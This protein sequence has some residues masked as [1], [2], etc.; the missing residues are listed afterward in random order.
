MSLLLVSLL[1]ALALVIIF[2]FARRRGT[3]SP[4]VPA[5]R[6]IPGPTPSPLPSPPPTIAF[7]TALTGELSVP[8]RID[9]TVTSASS[10][11][12]RIVPEYSTDG[13]VT[14]RAATERGGPPSE[15][16]GN[17]SSSPAG[18][19]HVFVWDAAADLAPNLPRS[20]FFAK[21]G[22]F[23]AQ[24]FGA[25]PGNTADTGPFD[26]LAGVRLLTPAAA[27]LA[28]QRNALW[29][30]PVPV[31]YLLVDQAA[32]PMNVTVT[33]SLDGGVTFL[34]A[35]E[36][37]GVG[38]EGVA[39]LASSD[40][41]SGG[42]EH[43]F[44]W[45]AGADLPGTAAT[46]VLL[47][48]DTQ[49][50][51]RGASAAVDIDRRFASTGTTKPP[52]TTSIPEID[53]IVAA[54]NIGAHVP[55]RFVVIDP[56]SNRVDVDVRVA[57]AGS[58]FAPAVAA[59]MSDTMTNLPAPP[60]WTQFR[61][62]WNAPGNNVTNGPAQLL[63]LPRRG[64]VQIGPAVTETVNVN[65][66]V[67]PDAGVLAYTAPPQLLP[68]TVDKLGGTDRQTG[69]IHAQLPPTAR[70][71]L[72]PR[73]LAV[74]VTDTSGNP[75][76]GARVSFEVLAGSPPIAFER[77]TQYWPTTDAIGTAGINVRARAGAPGT[78]RV[79]AT[80]VGA[81]NHST[82]FEFTL[83]AP[84][85]ELNTPLPPGPYGY[86][87]RVDVEVRY[88]GVGAANRVDFGPE[89]FRPRFLNV[90]PTNCV[91][92][93]ARVR[94]NGG[95]G[96]P[97]ARVAVFPTILD[98]TAKVRFEDPDDPTVFFE[99]LLA[100]ST[101][102]NA[103][104]TTWDAAG[105]PIT[106]P[107]IRLYMVP[108][109]PPFPPPPTATT[110]TTTPALPAALIGFPG[111]TLATAF[112]I[113]HVTDTT[114]VIYNKENQGP[115]FGCYLAPTPP[116]ASIPPLRLI[117]VA[118]N[119]TL[120][121][122]PGPGTSNTVTA[123]VGAPVY[124]TPAGA[125]PWF[126]T[127]STV[128]RI[129]DTRSFD[130]FWVDSSGNQQCNRQ[131]DIGSTV[132]Y[133]FV[134]QEPKDYRF[135]LTAGP[136]A[137]AVVT[138]VDAGDRA[139]L[140][141]TIST[142]VAGTPGDIKFAAH[143]PGG[144]RP[145]AYTLNGNAVQFAPTARMRVASAGVLHSDEFAVARDWQST[146]TLPVFIVPFGWIEA[147]G[148]A[149]RAP[150]AVAGREVERQTIAG[151][152]SLQEAA[153]G[154]TPHLGAAGSVLAHGGEFVYGSVDLS[155]RSRPDDMSFGRTYC[156]HLKSEGM[157]GPGW[158]FAHERSLELTRD[159]GFR[160]YNGTGRFDD[161]TGAQP[162]PPKGIFVEV[163]AHTQIDADRSAFEITYP[164][165]TVA[166]FNY[167]GSLRFIRDRVRNTV[168]YRY[169]EQARLVEI[170]DPLSTGAA[171]PRV[172]RLEYWTAG[173]GIAKE[174]EGKLKQ[175]TDFAGRQ[176]GFEY[177]QATGPDGAAGWLKTVSPP[178]APAWI[179]GALDPNHRRS[180]SYRY[181]VD[182]NDRSKGVLREIVD[183]EGRTW[184]KNAHDAD[185]RVISQEYGDPA[186]SRQPYKFTY[187]AGVP[188][189]GPGALIATPAI[190]STTTMSDRRGTKSEYLFPASPYWD[191]CAPAFVCAYGTNEI[192]FHTLQ[193]NADGHTVLY[194]L[195]AGAGT[196]LSPV[197]ETRFAY[198]ERATVRSRGNLRT[199]IRRSSGGE[200][201]VW[202]YAYDPTYNYVSRSADARANASGNS[203][204]LAARYYY[205]SNGNLETIL[206]PSATHLAVAARTNNPRGW[207]EMRNQDDREI[208]TYNSFG[209]L[210]S[211]ADG[212]G[213]VTQYAYHPESAPG[214][215]AGAPSDAHGGFSARMEVDAVD[216]PRRQNHVPGPQWSASP[217]DTHTTKW[218]WNDVGDLIE[219]E[220]PDGTRTTYDADNSR[221]PSKVV[222][223]AG[224]PVAITQRFYHDEHSGI[225]RTELDQPSLAALSPAAVAK[226]GGSTLVHEWTRDLLGNVTAHSATLEQGRIVVERFEFDADDCI[227]RHRPVDDTSGRFAGAYTQYDRDDRGLAT[228]VTHA[229]G[230]TGSTARKVDWTA[231][232]VIGTFT[233]PANDSQ[234]S[235]R[236][237]YGDAIGAV[238]FDQA[239]A[240][241]LHDPNATKRRVYSQK[242]E[243]GN[244]FVHFDETVHDEAGRLMRIHAGVFRPDGM[245]PPPRP[246]PPAVAIGEPNDSFF[247]VPSF[248][249]V[250]LA[251]APDGKWGRGDGRSTLDL[252]Y[253]GPH[254]TRVVDDEGAFAWARRDAHGR[255]VETYES[256]RTR[257]RA[258]YDKN[259]RIIE[260]E[261]FDESSTVT[262]RTRWQKFEYDAHGR[263]TRYVDA[264]GNTYAFEYDETGHCVQRYD[265]MGPPDTAS[266]PYRG[267]ALNKPGNATRFERDGFG[268]I[269]KTE[270]ALTQ[271]GTSAGAPDVTTFNPTA[272]TGIDVAYDEAGRLLSCQGQTGNPISWQYDAI[273]R[274]QSTTYSGCRASGGQP[275]LK[276]ITYDGAGRM[277]TS[278]DPNATRLR[279]TYDKLGH[280]NAIKV[281]VRGSGVVGTDEL[282]YEVKDNVVTATD[283]TSGFVSRA[284]DDSLGRRIFAIEG[285]LVL[286]YEYDG[287]GLRTRLRRPDGSEIGYEHDQ[288]R[289]LRTVRDGNQVITRLDYLSTSLVQFRIQGG[290]QT[291]YRYRD[292]TLWL[293][294]ML[295]G[296]VAGGLIQYRLERDRMGRITKR[297]RT[298]AGAVTVREWR[299]DSVGRIVFERVTGTAGVVETTRLYDSDGALRRETV[300]A[301]G[302]TT[303]FDQDSEERGRILSRAGT[304]YG[305]DLAGHLL[306]DGAQRYAWDACSRLM[307]V[308]RGAQVIAEYEYDAEHRC[309]AKTAGTRREEYL[310]DDW[311]LIEV[312]V[313]GPGT[314]VVSERYVWSDRLDDL[315]AIETNG[316]K[317]I[318]LYTPEGWVDALVDQQ[319][320]IVERYEYDLAGRVTV[321]DASGTPVSNARPRSRFLFQRRIYDPDTGLYDYR[322]R[323]Y[324]PRI[325]QFLTPDPSG[326]IEGPDHYWLNHGDPVNNV[327][328]Y[329]M[330][331]KPQQGEDKRNTPP[332][333]PLLPLL[334]NDAADAHSNAL[335]RRMIDAIPLREVRGHWTTLIEPEKVGQY[336]NNAQQSG[337][338]FW[339]YEKNARAPVP[340]RIFFSEG[341]A[342][343]YVPRGE[344]RMVAA[345]QLLGEKAT[346]KDLR[347]YFEEIKDND[348]GQ[349]RRAVTSP[350]K[351]G[352]LSDAHRQFLRTGQMLEIM[353][354]E[355]FARWQAQAKA[356]E[357]KPPPA[358][359]PTSTFASALRVAGTIVQGILVG[360][361]IKAVREHGLFSVQSADAI[362]DIPPYVA[363]VKGS[364][365][366]AKNVYFDALLESI[367]AKAAQRVKDPPPGRPNDPTTIQDE[368]VYDTAI[369]RMS[370][371]SYRQYLQRRQ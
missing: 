19:A 103:Q 78:G 113:D 306:D 270:T 317:Y 158:S 305:Y 248:P 232:A 178:V 146:A 20:D 258:T 197:E 14:Y 238:D 214:G 18:T 180:E 330:D 280:V 102:N 4:P 179:N 226:A 47:R 190:A 195:A 175:L 193:H 2:F 38:S 23:R 60:H 100:V 353:D 290:I 27:T 30:S 295:I 281:E 161:F 29:G 224:T 228:T 218:K 166:H 350:I 170:T 336:V 216:S 137:G 125:G 173:P 73:S 231:N 323:W 108:T 167:D 182:P 25:Q 165:M 93:Q 269:V 181:D 331:D 302:T 22:R 1:L 292:G 299:Y 34:P 308:S 291:Q 204:M 263:M 313:A 59:P 358:T 192:R 252:S 12:V 264:G 156:G 58:N 88:D 220:T 98:G 36:A 235:V 361:A 128:G 289:M 225:A 151:I 7:T 95:T 207:R 288:T 188:A 369:G 132:S 13:G 267:N 324:H 3:S 67:P 355:A 24:V 199:V 83:H 314:P 31:R 327:D 111:L 309:I 76:Q 131:N 133:T 213:V 171:M 112:K 349:A 168:R 143:L 334:L 209:L 109:S 212:R 247:G 74:R 300:N 340:L 121:T 282:R 65:A 54:N 174:V 32:D 187:A 244:P 163:A 246:S 318:V 82:T 96:S 11:R 250:A 99:V 8:I 203:E 15:G 70:G 278:T 26:V 205:T 338:I 72:L 277:D 243:S 283:A 240:T 371:R 249:G 200:E 272:T 284:I 234:S 139:R 28:G 236:D 107:N 120:S 251:S 145:P 347:G 271:D 69:F 276:S 359:A 84:K 110:T 71:H 259:H 341:R 41:A 48:I 211:H 147:Q 117:Y 219:E 239:S 275:T 79:K 6:P 360:R 35:T 352:A 227:Q 268:R 154:T 274:L 142:T 152:E 255:P 52:P 311:H 287:S 97:T 64:G 87:R 101:A 114:G 325:G 5:P 106:D 285:P 37:A 337:R 201:R 370:G 333:V 262:P 56:D 365:K 50:G 157:L 301:S 210:T 298:V 366:L 351:I 45:N 144:A 159:T 91:V 221:R 183:S 253:D 206:R 329:G 10:E 202:S 326:F 319:G 322:M 104:R 62:V 9:Y 257:R 116:P 241:G 294:E 176:V 208:F 321:L 80:V 177:Y 90:T 256:S 153:T 348:L 320:A 332:V 260:L 368:A 196:T 162:M 53:S 68:L 126:I 119:G 194:K 367:A 223:A 215:A 185:A 198:D 66:S 172:V 42:I 296:G 245:L 233:N 89:P 339:D 16:L 138:T 141:V 81:P 61:F 169:D 149:L 49:K 315:L 286:E 75:V 184:L 44:A 135:V 362:T 160:Y 129:Y 273:G 155:F 293:E 46:G 328:P 55:I 230:V 242:G 237:R 261:V 335:R 254:L 229:P 43:Y 57:A 342:I 364:L 148:D 21:D 363:Q 136:N 297:T 316:V 115:G 354:D 51:G 127:A 310:Y 164:D 304:Q 189:A 86:N 40:H 124:F 217:L 77:S 265:A 39:G 105:N 303:P 92:A 118:S 356:A 266:P 33:Y 312:R 85:I 345:L 191:A 94:L 123:S 279:Y 17:L 130:D 346:L 222:R 63:F 343:A 307:R 357:A 344:T 150:I 122:S 140:E 186:V 134:V